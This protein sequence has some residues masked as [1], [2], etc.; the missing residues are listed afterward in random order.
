MENKPP[1]S[2]R[3]G[4]NRQTFDA[5]MEATLATHA[6]ALRTLA[7]YEEPAD[8]VTVA[9]KY[10]PRQSDFDPDQAAK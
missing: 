5:A 3:R 9:P 10:Q 1:P 7:R 4:R 6:D 8:E 2:P